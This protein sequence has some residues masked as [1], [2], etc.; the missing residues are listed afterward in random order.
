VDNQEVQGVSAYESIGLTPAMAEE[1][2]Q[3]VVEIFN[4]IE[5][6]VQ[7]VRLCRTLNDYRNVHQ[8]LSKHIEQ[9]SDAIREFNMDIERAERALRRLY[10]KGVLDTS[11]E[12]APIVAERKQA[13]LYRKLYYSFGR[14]YRMVGDALAWKI[15]GFQALPIYAYGMN[16]SPGISANS[17]QEGVRAEE[18]AV[19]KLWSEQGAFALRHDY[20]NCLRVWDLSVL[21]PGS[22]T[23]TVVEV[24]IGGRP[25]GRE[26]KDMG[27]RA[28]ELIEHGESSLP[29]GRLLVQRKF[30]VEP[31]SGIIQSNLT[32]LA[33]AITQARTNTIG[34]ATNE[35]LAIAVMDH[36]N[37][38]QRTAEELLKEWDELTAGF[39]PSEIWPLWP[40]DILASNSREKITKPGFCAPYT[41]YPFP[42]D[43]VAGLVTGLIQV[44]YSLNTAEVIRA[45]HN[46]GFE[47]E[48]LIGKWREQGG[49][50]PKK[51]QGPYFRVSRGMWNMLVHDIAIEQVL[52][53]GLPLEE[54]VASI[55]AFY[56]AE[57]G[58]NYTTSPF[59]NTNELDDQHRFHAMI[60]YTSMEDVWRASEVSI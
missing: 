3:R 32:L 12:A 40:S 25:I 24:K 14:M 17:R 54:L 60:T 18:E 48:C 50:P 16:S 7:E 39:I 45:F 43:F 53:D 22:E 52:F 33:Q 5:E 28:I 34:R 56:D 9:V 51:L 20:T 57:F 23:P 38:A 27:R 10:K 8:H 15:Y 42:S 1:F 26:Q 19:E 30:S 6:L 37:P 21:H 47:A 36:T 35:Y 44:H 29:D 13:K 31:S 4:N 46:A 2:N 58:Q 41:I 49:L 59:P 11:T 55:S